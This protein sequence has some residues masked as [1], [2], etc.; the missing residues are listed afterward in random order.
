MFSVS[1][2]TLILYQILA[3]AAFLSM[4][5]FGNSTQWI[6]SISMYFF[7]VTIGGTITYH[8][9]LSHRSF[10]SPKWFEYF[11]SIIGA[12][13]GNGSGITWAAIHREHHRFT[14]QEKDPHSPL[15]QS[16]F[17]IQFLSMLDTPKIRY[18]P[19]LLRSKFHMWVHQYYWIINFIYVGMLLI[20][21][22]FAI[23]YAYFIPT[24]LVWHGGSFINT[25]NH[26]I[27]Y[28]NYESKDCSTNN[29]FTGLLVSGEGW[30]N[31]HHHSPA[32]SQFGKRWFE[33][34]LGYL[35]IRLI[36]KR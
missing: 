34:D 29:I 11:G 36:R 32:D 18:V 16:F 5:L 9:L 31:N 8:R 15:Y 14:D 3:H 1:K 28:R 2:N 10:D 6:I 20:I 17:K 33:F 23:V 35:I 7:M 12:I 24:L 25:V 19:D 21:D 30:H 22:P 13:G 27:G 26:V 4:C